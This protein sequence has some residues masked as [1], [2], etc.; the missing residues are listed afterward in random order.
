MIH[1]QLKKTLPDDV[2]IRM[3]LC[4][5]SKGPSSPTLFL[6]IR[7]CCRF[8]APFGRIGGPSAHR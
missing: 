3:H 4:I 1:L 2:R 7:P 6:H 8:A 5:T